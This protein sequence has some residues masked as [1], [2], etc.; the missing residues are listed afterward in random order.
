MCFLRCEKIFFL[1]NIL[2]Y[3][4]RQEFIDLFEYN[5][6]RLMAYCRLMLEGGCYSRCSSVCI[7]KEMSKNEISELL[8]RSKPT[9]ESHLHLALKDRYIF[10]ALHVLMCKVIDTCV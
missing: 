1:N 7:E 6:P 5:Y 3:S 2:R 10:V 9:I 8:D 4:L